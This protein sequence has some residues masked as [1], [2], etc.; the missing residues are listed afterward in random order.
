M[1]TPSLT[2]IG[3][4]PYSFPE[5]IAPGFGTNVSEVFGKSILSRTQLSEEHHALATSMASSGIVDESS[6]SEM[7]NR[8]VS[9]QKLCDQISSQSHSK[10]QTLLN[11]AS[12]KQKAMKPI[13]VFT[14]MMNALR[15]HVQMSFSSNIEDMSNFVEL[16]ATTLQQTSVQ[17]FSTIMDMWQQT[18]TIH[19]SEIDTLK[20]FVFDN[21]PP[22]QFN[23]VAEKINDHVKSLKRADLELIPTLPTI[24]DIYADDVEVLRWL[25]K[26]SVDKQELASLFLRVSGIATRKQSRAPSF[27]LAIHYIDSIFKLFV[28]ALNFKNA[29][30]NIFHIAD[31]L[32]LYHRVIST[33]TE[34]FL[35]AVEFASVLGLPL[36]SEFYYYE[37]QWKSY[38]LRE[39]AFNTINSFQVSDNPE[40]KWVLHWFGLDTIESLK[41]NISFIDEVRSLEPKYRLQLLTTPKPDTT[42]S[43][44]FIDEWAR[45]LDN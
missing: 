2:L 27:V 34:Q 3:K 43:Q 12:Q 7:R 33:S 35:C 32:E 25:L 6:L 14:Q 29:V 5:N 41:S 17:G 36:S 10:K 8:F 18:E 1:E 24:D 19:D 37:S 13:L 31:T 23:M 30:A 21:K 16:V 11:V 26:K 45:E 28:G 38:I 20:M 22:T 9:K 4:S 15:E 39:S 40:N 44:Y 42:T